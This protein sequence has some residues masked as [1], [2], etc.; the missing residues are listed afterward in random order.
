MWIDEIVLLKCYEELSVN[1]FIP[2]TT[3]VVLGKSNNVSTEVFEEACAKDGVKI[4]RRKGGGGTVVLHPGCVV[5]TVGTWVK[6]FYANLKYFNLLNQ[7]LIK[8]LGELNTL[9]THI[10]E[11]GISDLTFNGKKIAGSSLFRSKGYL[12]YQVS[13]LVE[14]HIALIE[15]YLKHPTKEPEYRNKKNHRDFISSLQ[16]VVHEIT[17]DLVEK[18]LKATLK[19]SLHKMLLEEFITPDQK[20]CDTLLKGHSIS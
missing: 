11:K 9:F 16:E 7:A 3:C 15:K 2:H 1:I 20:H 12:L 18:H 5:V 4:L 19:N 10:E 14:S 6:D 17:P 13:L 8:N